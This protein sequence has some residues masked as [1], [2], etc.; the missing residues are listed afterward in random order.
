MAVT[1]TSHATEFVVLVQVEKSRHTPVTILSLGMRLAPTDTGVG[2]AG[3]VVVLTSGL[4]AGA[5]ATSE[6]RKVVVVGKATI[7]LVTAN[8]R[9]ASASSQ[10]VALA[11]L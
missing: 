6:R 11:R 3:R 4:N 7:A 10:T 9:F 5:R 1:K 2:L 8:A